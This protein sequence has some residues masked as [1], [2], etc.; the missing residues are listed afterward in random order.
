MKNSLKI[1]VLLFFSL[2]APISHA[3]APTPLLKP[4]VL[5]QQNSNAKIHLVAAD[6]RKKLQDA[7]FNFVGTYIPDSNSEVMIFTDKTMLDTA[8]QTQY[9][10]FGSAMRVSIVQVGNSVQVAFINPEY[11]ALAYHMKNRLKSTREKLIKALGYVKDF[12]GDGIAESELPKYHY[13]YGLEGFTG[14]MELAEFK[15]HQEALNSVEKGLDR[16]LKQISKV[17]RIDVP[18]KAQSIFGLSLNNDV[19]D[20]KFLSDKYVMSVIDH[21]ELRRAA[22]LPYEIMVTGNRVIMMHPHFRLAMNFPDLRMFGSN[23]FGKLMS[24]PYVYEEFFIQVVGG[25]PRT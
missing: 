22:H 11:M 9:G 12:G 1:S 16:K 20:E 23:S 7:G 14:F 3:A 8:A 4:F 2:I 21:Q 24:L 17:Y 13:A 25:L 6:V 18:G 10:G 19:K 5:A 15:T